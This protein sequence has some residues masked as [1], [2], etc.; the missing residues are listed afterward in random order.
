VTSGGLSSSIVHPRE[1][2]QR[3]ILQ[4]AAAIIL[5]HNHPSGSTEPSQDDIKVTN[6]LVQAGK[7][8]GIEVL[9]HIIIGDSSF[10]SMKQHDDIF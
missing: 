1:V 10:R 7:I 6:K 4:G 2:F 9:D 3:A 5:C 8:V